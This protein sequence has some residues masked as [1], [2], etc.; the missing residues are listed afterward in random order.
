MSLY[1]N[2][3]FYLTHGYSRH[4]V[5]FSNDRELGLFEFLIDEFRCNPIQYEKEDKF[6]E[7]IT[8]MKEVLKEVEIDH[9]VENTYIIMYKDLVL[10]ISYEKYLN[11]FLMLKGQIHSNTDQ[12]ETTY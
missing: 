1:A 5:N 8:A 11:D 7:L 3:N 6:K 9:S 2:V 12:I 4:I 10:R